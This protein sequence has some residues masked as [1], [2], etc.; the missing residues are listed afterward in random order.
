MLPPGAP[1]CSP[2]ALPCSL[3][4]PSKAA[5]PLFLIRNGNHKS[6]VRGIHNIYIYIH[7]RDFPDEF[8]IQAFLLGL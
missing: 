4:T 2:G 6:Q 3:A 1:L 5:L 8:Q 7:L